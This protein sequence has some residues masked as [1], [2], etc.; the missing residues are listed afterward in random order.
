MIDPAGNWSDGTPR[1]RGRLRLADGTKSERFD[2]PQGMNEKQA[3]KHV[4]G[5]QA[6]EDVQQG[7]LNAKLEA[8]RVAAVRA[9]LPPTVDVTEG[10]RWFDTWERSRVAKGLTSTS[11]NRA[12]FYKHVYP[13]IGGKFL[14][15]WTVDD[16]RG[17]VRVLD[18]K[19][20]ATEISWKYAKNAWGTVRKMCS[21]SVRS[22]VDE[23]RVRTDDPC[24][25]VL[26]PDRGENR[27]KPFL[28]PSEFLTFAAC[29][30][31]PLRWRLAVTLAIYLFP[32][33]GELRVLRWEDGAV[34]L[35]H[36]TIHIHR[37]WD[38]RARKITS[39]K[40]GRARRFSIESAAP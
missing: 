5:M 17:I 38:R 1:F 19:V 28:Y 6:I 8:R 32:R 15:D 24:V 25:N 7:F 26:G 34:D 27:S 20:Q 39:T 3:R 30:D 11:D 36:G 18:A 13:S 35:E 23:L 10:E 21:D 2:V 33:H 9:A 4:A 31:V 22:K 37:A 29:E 12:H 14:R 40:T 16:V